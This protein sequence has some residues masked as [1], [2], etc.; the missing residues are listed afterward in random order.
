MKPIRRRKWP[1]RSELRHLDKTHP[2]KSFS[3]DNR[4]K[5]S[6]IIGLQNLSHPH[7]QTTTDGKTVTRDFEIRPKAKLLLLNNMSRLKKMFEEKEL[8]RIDIEKAY[9][10]NGKASHTPE[11]LAKC[12]EMLEDLWREKTDVD[13]HQVILFPEK[14]NRPDSIDL[15]TAPIPFHIMVDLYGVI[16]I[17][18]DV[19]PAVPDA[20]P[21]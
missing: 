5:E 13:L 21:K 14:T 19:A 3:L 17:E 16:L 8:R 6:L 1:V 2:M 10:P 4:Q 12:N 11:E 7:A 15:E 20:A 9:I 18:P